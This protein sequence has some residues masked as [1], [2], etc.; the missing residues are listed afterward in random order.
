[1]SKIN[2]NTSVQE[3]SV[4]Y[5]QDI[6]TMEFHY[7]HLPCCSFFCK[8]KERFHAENEVFL[9]LFAPCR[10]AYV[11]YRGKVKFPIASYVVR[12]YVAN[13]ESHQPACRGSPRTLVQQTD[14]S[15]LPLCNTVQFNTTYLCALVEGLLAVPAVATMLSRNARV[16]QQRFS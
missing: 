1:M 9:L 14:L 16:H 4:P 12:S 10:I 6:K 11:E 13:P 3:R 8:K 5:G 7:V 15:S 2:S